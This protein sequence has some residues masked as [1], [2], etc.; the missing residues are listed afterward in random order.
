M[1]IVILVGGDGL[2]GVSAIILT[3]TGATGIL[4]GIQTGMILIGIGTLV[5]AGISVGAILIIMAGAV[6]LTMA[7]GMAEAGEDRFLTTILPIAEEEHRQD[8]AEHPALWH[9]QL[10][11]EAIVLL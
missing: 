11:L 6:I 3:D 4:H 10:A 8:T 5:L 9:Q 7:V 1:S 2:I